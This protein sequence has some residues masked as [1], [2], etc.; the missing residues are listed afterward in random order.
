MRA[1]DFHPQPS[2]PERRRQIRVVLLNPG[3]PEQLW[4]IDFSD[5]ETGRKEGGGMG[6]VFRKK[7]KLISKS[8]TLVNIKHSF[9]SGH[10]LHS[11]IHL[12][13]C[14]MEMNKV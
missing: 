12:R 9:P 5:A 10:L 1:P 2:S 7:E 6:S 11:I 8:V 4:L 14:Y 3:I 13:A